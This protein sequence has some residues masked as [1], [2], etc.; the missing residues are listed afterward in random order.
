MTHTKICTK[1]NQEKE[2]TEFNKNKQGKDGLSSQCK[3][4]LSEINKQHYKENKAHYTEVRKRYY[5]ENKEQFTERGKQYYQDNAEHR[6]EY[7]KQYHQDNAER[8]KQYQQYNA[9]KIA[10]QKKQ[11]RQTPKGKAVDKAKSHNR[12]AQKHNNGGTHTGAEILQLFDL[13]SGMCPY[14]KIN[15]S[16]TGSNK[17]HCD[18]IVPL[19][20][21]GTNSIENIQLLCPK[22]NLTKNDKL[23]EEFAA[24]FGRLL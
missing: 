20:K 5:K 1:C 12:R 15:L 10:E 16:K 18:H 4:C 3:I 19:S 8:V 2:P 22:C 23:P 13:Q 21:G 7:S 11:Y 9:A 6:A 24:I 14:C 17:Y